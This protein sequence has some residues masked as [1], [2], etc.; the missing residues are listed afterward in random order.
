LL[1]IYLSGGA[2]WNTAE[3]RAACTLCLMACM[4]HANGIPNSKIRPTEMQD[5]M[6]TIT[7]VEGAS[8]LD[9]VD[10]SLVPR[11]TRMTRGVSA[12]APRAC[13][14]VHS[15][16]ACAPKQGVHPDTREAACRTS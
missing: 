10:A 7:P 2:G 12:S 8:P 5:A 6:P 1:F 9:E 15:L 11:G 14:V 13:D 16:A 4:L 3:I